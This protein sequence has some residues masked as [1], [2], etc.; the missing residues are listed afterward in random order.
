MV[1]NGSSKEER[2]KGKILVKRSI[3]G[4]MREGIEVLTVKT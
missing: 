1:L 3:L 4:S 2:E